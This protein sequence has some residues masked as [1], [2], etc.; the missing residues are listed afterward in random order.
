MKTT[1]SFAHIAIKLAVLPFAMI[2]NLFTQ[3]SFAKEGEYHSPFSTKASP[4]HKLSET[5]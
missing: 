1:A 4:L 3:S 2:N 5:F